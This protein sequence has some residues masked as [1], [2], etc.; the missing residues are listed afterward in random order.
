[1]SATGQ[2]PVRNDIVVFNITR[3]ALSASPRRSI[4]FVFILI[5]ILYLVFA[6]RE[7]PAAIAHFFPI[8]IVSVFFAPER[9]TKLG[10]ITIGALLI[11]LGVGGELLPLYYRIFGWHGAGS[12]RNGSLGGS[13]IAGTILGIVLL[14]VL[15][16]ARWKRAGEVS[17]GEDAERRAQRE[18]FEMLKRDPRFLHLQ[19]YLYGRGCHTT[20]ER[21]PDPSTY[22]ILYIDLWDANWQR[23][24]APQGGGARMLVAYLERGAAPTRLKVAL[25]IP[26]GA[27]TESEV[28]WAGWG[29]LVPLDPRG[30]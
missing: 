21:A 30:V 23:L 14:G 25:D 6:F 3:L 19:R 10:R 15:G 17:D 18:S 13:S 9:R 26:T 1:M 28:G 2:I 4:V 29:G 11:A 22:C 27:C 12:Q 7:P 5:G 20:F 24:L 8:P 16:L